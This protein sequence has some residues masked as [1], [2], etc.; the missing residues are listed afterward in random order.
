M[1]PCKAKCKLKSQSAFHF[2]AQTFETLLGPTTPYIVGIFCFRLHVAKGFDRFQTLRNNSQ[3]HVMTCNRMCKQTQQVTPNNFGSC[4]PTRL[5]PFAQGFCS[6]VRNWKIVKYCRENDVELV[7]LFSAHILSKKATRLTRNLFL[8][9][10]YSSQSS[11]SGQALKE[12][13]KLLVVTRVPF[14]YSATFT[15]FACFLHLYLLLR[16]WLH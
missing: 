14:L 1:G 5:L 12:Q 9:L 4:W 6:L 2:F 7:Y 3:Q 13:I 8:I 16:T 15:S 10:N 11:P